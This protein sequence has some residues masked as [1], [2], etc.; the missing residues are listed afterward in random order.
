MREEIIQQVDERKLIAIVRS[1]APE[2]CLE[3]A[4]ALK[5]GGI[6]MMEITFHQADPGSFADTTRAIS[7]IANEGEMAVGA[8]TV[9]TVEQVH[10]AADAGAQYIISPDTQEIVIRKTLEL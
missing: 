8:G 3:L 10:M 9:M 2:K 7:A 5:E 1:I 4:H 6:S